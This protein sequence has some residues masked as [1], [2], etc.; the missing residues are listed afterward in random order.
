MGSQVL[1]VPGM[2]K[3][4]TKLIECGVE[5]RDKWSGIAYA[6]GKFFCAPFKASTVLVID[7]ATGIGAEM[8]VAA[9]NAQQ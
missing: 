7:A 4:E 6:N 3:V 5:G 8:A 2:P 1:L 9:Y